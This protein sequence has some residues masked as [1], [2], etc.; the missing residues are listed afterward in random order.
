MIWAALVNATIGYGLLALALVSKEREDLRPFYRFA[1]AAAAIVAFLASVSFLLWAE[2]ASTLLWRLYY[3]VSAILMPSVSFAIA[4]LLWKIAPQQ[5]LLTKFDLGF[6]P[7]NDIL[8]SEL[9]ATA[10]IIFCIGIGVAAYMIFLA[11]QGTT[12]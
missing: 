11:V 10:V 6:D 9:R 3:V 8:S 7:L 2:N 5:E 4:L 1:K 12:P